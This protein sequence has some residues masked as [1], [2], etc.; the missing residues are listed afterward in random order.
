MCSQSTESEEMCIPQKFSQIHQQS[1]V[2][3]TEI[4]SFSR[5]NVQ[6]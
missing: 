3:L 4:V 2:N 1:E 6:E 5:L